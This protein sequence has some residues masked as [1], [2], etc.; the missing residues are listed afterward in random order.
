LPNFVTVDFGQDLVL[1]SKVRFKAW[2]GMLPTMA[3]KKGFNTI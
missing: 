2:G 1:R 3:E